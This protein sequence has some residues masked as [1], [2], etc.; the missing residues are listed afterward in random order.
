M[1]IT[2]MFLMHAVGYGMNNYPDL[3]FDSHVKSTASRLLPRSLV[4]E[5]SVKHWLLF[6]F[7]W[8]L[9]WF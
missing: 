1:F 8:H 7:L 6:W 4:S 3:H 2:G 9:P 5:E